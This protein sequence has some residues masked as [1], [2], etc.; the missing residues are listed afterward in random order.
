M[1]MTGPWLLYGAN[2]YTGQL[3]ARL[4]AARGHRPVLAGRRADAVCALADGLGLER[5]LFSLDQP[6]RIEEALAGMGLVLNCA[7]PFS[8][9]ARAVVDAC[10]RTRTH[11]LD[12]T[13]EIA[14]IEA[15]AARDAEAREAGVLLLPACGFDVVPTDCLALH[16]KERLPG[17]RRLALGF[18]SHGRV[19]RGTAMTALERLHQGVLVRRDGVL[20]PVRPEQRS[21]TIDFGRGPRRAIAIPWGDL[22]TAWRSTGIPDIVVYMAAPLRLRL[23]LR[24]IRLAPS[25]PSSPLARRLLVRAIRSGPAGPTGE[26]RRRRR[27]FVWGEVEDAEGRRAVSRLET[28]ESY[29]LTAQAAV[30]LVERALAGETPTGFQTPARAFGSGFVLGLEG[31]VRRDEETVG[32]PR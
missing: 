2:G 5:R 7:G 21:R 8:W 15:I 24:A 19:S 31:V 29:S 12:V 10:L 26:E 17:A 18:E 14:V 25:L 4:A 16:L 28:P 11:Y 6:A 9:T 30:A 20:T 13:G 32:T 27:A 22:S 3:V 23:F 1:P